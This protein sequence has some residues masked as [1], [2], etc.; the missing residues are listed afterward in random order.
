MKVIK[1][2]CTEASYIAALHK[3]D[4]LIALNPKKGTAEY[5][6]LDAIGNLVAKYEEIHFPITRLRTKQD[7]GSK[8]KALLFESVI[9]PS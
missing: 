1:P 5:A 4:E 3:I 8:R 6:E 7:L 2:I 9:L